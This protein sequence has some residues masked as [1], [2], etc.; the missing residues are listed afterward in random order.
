MA[1]PTR[2]LHPL[3]LALFLVLG[4]ACTPR[5]AAPVLE[6]EI[7]PVVVEPFP[8]SLAWTARGG[9]TVRA[10]ESGTEDGS[11]RDPFT[12]VNVLAV[13]T[14]GIRIRC[15]YCIP[16][17]DGWVDREDLVYEPTTPAEAAE[18]GL[19]EFVL[20]VR[21][22]AEQRD[23]S[24]LGRVMARDFTFSLSGGGGPVDAFRR[25]EFQGYRALDN[26]PALLDR[27]LATRDSIIW[28][29]PPAFL[30]DPWYTGM[31]AG[32]RRS[33]AGRWEWIYLVGGS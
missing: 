5:A 13:D 31:R 24:A 3:A 14:P 27:G 19:T 12:R 22:A 17:V 29:A 9:V 25:W 32:F 7:E 8:Y 1:R 2:S 11:V 26:L 30:S 6:P 18:R 10:D 23:E 4:S 28:V 16:S 33:P 15:L 21:A 20:A